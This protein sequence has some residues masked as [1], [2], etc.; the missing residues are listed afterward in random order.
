MS[1]LNEPG[2]ST[3]W[4]CSGKWLGAAT[5]IQV[6][7]RA[8]VF[9]S[10]GRFPHPVRNRYEHVNTGS[11][12]PVRSHEQKRITPASFNNGNPF[13]AIHSIGNAGIVQFGPPFFSLFLTP[14]LSLHCKE[15]N[16]A[17]PHGFHF[18]YLQVAFLAGPGPA[19]IA[20]VNQCW[21]SAGKGGK[22]HIEALEL[23]DD[24]ESGV[25][26]V[27]HVL[28]FRRSNSWREGT[29]GGRQRNR[30]RPAGRDPRVDDGTGIP[31]VFDS[32]E[33]R[34]I[35]DRPESSQCGLRKWSFCRPHQS[36][37]DEGHGGDREGIQ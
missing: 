36:A 17:L 34:L 25:A 6:E 7:R 32:S 26:R 15:Y 18:K 20:A 16:L 5:G 11:W 35:V 4:L 12:A 37:L 28:V 19:A 14:V 22:F 3:G 24:A 29:G 30:R 13:S 2:R 27:V 33:Q 23:L 1:G 9:V 8:A 10:R 31:P 21:A